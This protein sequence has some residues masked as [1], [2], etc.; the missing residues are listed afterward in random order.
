MSDIEFFLD[1]TPIGKGRPRFYR[2]MDHVGTYTPQRTAAY[3]TELFLKARAFAPRRPFLEPVILR[4][5]FFMP[6]PKSLK[7]TV[8]GTLHTKKPDLDNLIKASTDPLN[9]LFWEDDAQIVGIDALK[10]YSERPG[11]EYRITKA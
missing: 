6:I 10:Y 5:T 9:G 8:D 4:L 3:E 7:K 2:A 11:I 1:I